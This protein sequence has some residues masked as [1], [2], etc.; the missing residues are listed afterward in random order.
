MMVRP[1]LRL[2]LG[3]FSCAVLMMAAPVALGADAP[4]GTHEPNQIT[5]KTAPTLSNAD[6]PSNK[7]GSAATKPGDIGI[8][9]S[10]GA[11]PTGLPSTLTLPTGLPDLTAG[12]KDGR[13]APIYEPGDGSFKPELRYVDQFA[14]QS[15]ANLHD[16]TTPRGGHGHTGVGKQL[17]GAAKAAALNGSINGAAAV[18]DDLLR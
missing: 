18:L 1:M 6:R 10:D 13:G 7:V 5:V 15:S 4:V 16:L 9:R 14:S 17:A 8:S 3:S 11:N 2:L 12:I